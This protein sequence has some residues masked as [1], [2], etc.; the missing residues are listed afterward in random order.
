[1]RE[2]SR[3]GV[4]VHKQSRSSSSF[5]PLAKTTL[6][7]R[8]EGAIKLHIFNEKLE[9]GGDILPSERQAAEAL[10]VSRETYPQ[11]LDHQ[12]A[13]IRWINNNRFSRFR[14]IDLRWRP[15]GQT[16]VRT[17][18]VVELEVPG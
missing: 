7:Q 5:Y 11:C 4:A 13:I 12:T 3:D 15:I 16:L 10:A 8:V 2:K 1:M 14:E 17:L 9:P 18:I 6:A